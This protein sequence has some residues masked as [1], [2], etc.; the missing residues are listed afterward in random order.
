MSK[1]TV[2]VNRAPVMTLW[3]AVVAERL[4]HDPEAALTLGKVVAGLNAQ[5]KGRRLGI[6]HEAE[7][8]SDRDEAATR[9]REG[10]LLLT[11]LG[12]SVPAVRTAEG[13]RATAKG[14]PVDPRSVQ[15]Y[16]TQKFGEDL[17]AVRSAMETLA[18]SLRPEELEQRA[19]SLD[20]A[21]RPKVPENERGWGA[22]GVLDLDLIRSLAG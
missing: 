15:R 2:K 4:G 3:A 8:S 9:P 20:Q 6:F 18:R 1:P 7:G 22:K 12:R 10:K 13:V 17:D 11:L 5:A 21:F 16:L 14:E 19:Y